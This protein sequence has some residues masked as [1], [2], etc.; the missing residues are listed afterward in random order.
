MPDRGGD[1][2]ESAETRGRDADN[3]NENDRPSKKPRTKPVQEVH[4][5]RVREVEECA[6][7][8][9]HEGNYTMDS[10]LEVLRLMSVPWN[11]SRR[12]VVPEGSDG[13]TQGAIP[14]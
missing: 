4:A 11:R 3:E 6:A 14:L 2:S 8:A 13:V 10:L 12:N 1:R 7:R 9:C 5:F